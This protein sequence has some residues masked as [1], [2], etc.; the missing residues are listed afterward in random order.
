MSEPEIKEGFISF[1]K[2]F[3]WGVATSAPQIEGGA[4]ED[5][6][7]ANIWDVF[8]RIPGMSYQGQ[9][10]DDACDHYHRFREDIAL[11]K[12]LGI[13]TYRFSFSWSRILPEGTG[14]VNGKGIAFYKEMLACL[15]ENGII[16]NATVYHW[17]LPYCLQLKGGFGNR[18]IMKWYLEYIKVLLDN[19]GEDVR[20]WVTFNEPIAVY[21]GY[22]LGIFA[23]GLK[24]EAYARQC[25]HNL[26]LC[27]GEAVRLFRT[28][29]FPESKIGIVVDMWP[30]Y[31]ADPGNEKDRELAL[32]GNEV[33][34]FGQFLNPIFL[35]D[36]S[37]TWYEYVKERNVLPEIKE[38]DL[39]IISEPLDFYGLNCYNAVFDDS[40]AEE[41]KFKKQGGGNFQETEKAVYHHRVIYD[42]LRLLRDKYK[43]NIPVFITENGMDCKRETE[44]DGRVFDEDRVEYLKGILCW[45][46]KAMEEGAD[47]RGYYLWTLMDNFEWSSGFSPKFGIVRNNPKTQIRTVKESAYWYKACIENSGFK[48]YRGIPDEIL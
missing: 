24:D 15:K 39:K 44:K 33:L 2:D 13:Q 36:Y 45:L 29:N 21:V 32:Y 48:T 40:M 43:V 23:P 20:Y 31:P 3:L 19:F 9:T 7:T 42:N 26:L 28:Y 46:N 14:K 10:P 41:K 18:D 17:D 1:P 8:C 35:G 38:G 12:E 16:P 30:H 27:H 6:K 4:F 5:G 25:L 34:G 22:G 37:K 47:V 11:M